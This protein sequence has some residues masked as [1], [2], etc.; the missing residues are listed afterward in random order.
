MRG[1]TYMTTLPANH[2]TQPSFVLGRQ[3]TPIIFCRPLSKCGTTF[4]VTTRDSRSLNIFKTRINISNDRTE[5]VYYNIG[6]KSGQVSHARLRMD[7]STL[8]DHLYRRSLV[9]SRNCIC[10][11]RETNSHFL[12]ECN[13]YAEIRRNTIHTLNFHIDIDILLKGPDALPLNRTKMQIYF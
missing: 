10:G 4:Q 6:S 3:Y 13:S 11:Q 2:I 12:L 9:A 8:N 1:L 7:S 5:P